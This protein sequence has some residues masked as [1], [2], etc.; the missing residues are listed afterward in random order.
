M[1]SIDPYSDEYSLIF[2]LETRLRYLIE[3]ELSKI[4]HDWWEKLI[5]ERTRATAEDLRKRSSLA[6]RRRACTSA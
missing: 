3:N 4:R 1:L 5:P 6:R 2:E